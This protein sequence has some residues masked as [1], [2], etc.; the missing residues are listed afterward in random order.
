MVNYLVYQRPLLARFK[1][2]LRKEVLVGKLTF[3]FI[4]MFKIYALCLKDL[5]RRM[6]MGV[7]S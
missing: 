5:W 3:C 6:K 1:D 2:V 7:S 4:S